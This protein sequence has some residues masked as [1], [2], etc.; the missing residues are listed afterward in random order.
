MVGRQNVTIHG[1]KY[2]LYIGSRAQVWHGTAYKLRSGLTRKDLL[3]NKHDR[4]VSRKKHN[5][6]KRQ[7]QLVKAGYTT[8]KGVFKLASRN[9]K[10]SG[11]RS[12]S[13]RG[14]KLTAFS[15]ASFP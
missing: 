5:I 7:K 11:G 3:K 10:M 13:Y 1:K 8:K 9:S 6:A 14:G 15:P 2:P 4:I 12:R